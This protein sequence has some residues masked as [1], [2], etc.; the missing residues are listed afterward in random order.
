MC[1][2]CTAHSPWNDDILVVVVAVVSGNSEA[3]VE[4]SSV[5]PGSMAC[6]VGS[7]TRG[8][9]IVFPTMRKEPPVEEWT[10]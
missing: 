2:D 9:P 3:L 10:S 7:N 5:N 6:F 4:G 1:S 8:F